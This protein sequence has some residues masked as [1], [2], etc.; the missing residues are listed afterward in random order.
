M[1]Y[2]IIIVIIFVYTG[3]S[4]KI[5]KVYKKLSKD[6]VKTKDFKELI[7]KNVTVMLDDDYIFSPKG[8]L[9]SYDDTWIEI[10][11]YNK[12]NKKEINFYRVSKIQSITLDVKSN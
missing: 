6:S 11:S 9:K 1:E 3:L 2:V 7:G 5:D 4:S 10:E 8:I 12:K